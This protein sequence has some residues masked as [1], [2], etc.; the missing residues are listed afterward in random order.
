VSRGRVAAAALLCVSPV[1]LSCS[2]NGDANASAWRRPGGLP[3]PEIASSP[4]PQGPSPTITPIADIGHET[5]L[6]SLRLWGNFL[7]Y[8]AEG[9]SIVVCDVRRGRV[10]DI[11]TV[12]EGSPAVLDY[13]VGSG[14]IVVYSQLSRLP[15]V[16]TADDAAA[17]TIESFDLRNGERRRLARSGPA[18]SVGT[19]YDV[20]PIPSI[21][22]PWVAWTSVTDDDAGPDTGGKRLRSGEVHTFDLRTGRRR[23]VAAAPM[24]PGHA[25]VTRGIVVFDGTVPGAPDGSR[26]IFVVPA[27]GSAPPRQLTTQGRVRPPTA[28]DGR[29][30]WRTDASGNGPEELW[31]MALTAS[32]PTRLPSGTNPVP[33]EDIVVAVTSKR[34]AAHVAAGSKTVTLELTPDPDRRL[35]DFEPR[36]DV[37]GGVVAWSTIERPIRSTPVRH[38][39][40]ALVAPAHTS[41]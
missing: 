41:P 21:E 29:V 12:E 2:G 25:S 8:A 13:V 30:A 27:D 38:L 1:L 39:H 9:R 33:G 20:L 40:L 24:R 32:E 37:E 34:L 16:D 19:E 23:T 35:L 17:W 36:W 28:R 14:D 31:T 5:R 26:D 6:S 3:C 7:A 18:G 22:W 11:A 15:E 4:T 10:R